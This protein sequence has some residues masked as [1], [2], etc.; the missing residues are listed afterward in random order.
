MTLKHRFKHD[1]CREISCKIYLP[2]AVCETQ[3][4]ASTPT[5]TTWSLFSNLRDSKTSLV[6]IEN[7]TFSNSGILTARRCLMLGTHGPCLDTLCIAIMAGIP[8]GLSV[9]SQQLPVDYD[10]RACQF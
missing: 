3:I 1:I 10:D 2:K 7:F 6:N 5:T 8:N 4:C 9:P